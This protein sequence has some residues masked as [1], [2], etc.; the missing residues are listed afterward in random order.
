MEG[1]LKLTQKEV[2]L[3][4]ALF[5]AMSL[6]PSPSLHQYWEDCPIFGM[7]FCQEAIGRDKWLEIHHWLHFDIVW[8]ESELQ[9]NF[10]KYWVPYQQIVT[11]FVDKLPGSGYYVTMDSYYGRLSTAKELLKKRKKAYFIMSCKADQPFK[12]MHKSMKVERG[13]MVWQSGERRK[14]LAV[15]WKDK[16][17]LNLLTNTVA[18]PIKE[19][20]ERV[21]QIV[22]H[23]RKTLNF[24]DRAN[25]YRMRYYFKHRIFKHTRA[26]FI[27]LFFLTAANARILYNAVNK[28]NMRHKDFLKKLAF[29][30]RAKGGGKQQNKRKRAT[31]MQNCNEPSRPVRNKEPLHY[32]KRV[33]KRGACAHCKASAAAGNCRTIC[34]GCTANTGD[35]V[36]LHAERKDCFVH[37][38]QS[39]E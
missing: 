4:L 39:L 33:E 3:Y 11:D 30:F 21:P 9:A 10:K 34:V 8:I 29:E 7:H 23:Y 24:V 15:C 18:K 38:H 17:I 12:Q 32:P 1:E 16:K 13:A 22:S 35:V 25:S 14:V 6:S 26:Q 27:N 20:R 19:G 5:L 36:Y 31:K 28:K 37:F 2:F